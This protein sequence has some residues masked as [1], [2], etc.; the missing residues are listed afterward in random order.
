M[1]EA[2]GGGEQDEDLLVPLPFI[3]SHRARGDF[4]QEY[5]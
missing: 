2:E 1:G 5:V 3:P 4:L